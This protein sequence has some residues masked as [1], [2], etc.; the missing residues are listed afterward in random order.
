MSRDGMEDTTPENQDF[1]LGAITGQS[2]DELSQPVVIEIHQQKELM[3]EISNLLGSLHPRDA[4]VIRGL[5]GLDGA[6]QKTRY[7]I[8]EELGITV[9]RIRQ[10]ESKTM[11]KLRFHLTSK[12][13]LNLLDGS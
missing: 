1:G 9:E 2:E 6:K 7:E 5:V 11:S 8:S 3:T 12:G 13:R 4:E 10:I